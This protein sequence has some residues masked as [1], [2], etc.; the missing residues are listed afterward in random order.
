[1]FNQILTVLATVTVVFPGVLVF[2][3]LIWVAS[4]ILFR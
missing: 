4:P 2:Y 1:M 3:K